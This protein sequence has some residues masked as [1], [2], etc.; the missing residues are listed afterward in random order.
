MKMDEAN[1]GRL[2]VVWGRC[3]VH[4]RLR[5]IG[6][7]K[8]QVYLQLHCYLNSPPDAHSWLP[9]SIS[10]PGSSKSATNWGSEKTL[11][12]CLTTGAS[13]TLASTVA[14]PSF[15]AFPVSSLLA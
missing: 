11:I 4:Q 14:L 13:S 5:Q 2:L 3:S 9:L 8:V 15:I 7:I 6:I 1:V 12:F 10:K